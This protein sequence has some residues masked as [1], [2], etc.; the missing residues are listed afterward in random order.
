MSG[1]LYAESKNVNRANLKFYRA[2]E[3]LDYQL[4][5]SVWLREEYVKCVHPGAEMIIGYEAV[6]YSWKQIF[7]HTDHIRFS[8]RDIDVRVNGNLAWVTLTECVEAGFSEHERG[9]V[10]AA[11]NIF[12]KRDGQWFMIMH[13]SSPMLRRIGAE[14][15]PDVLPGII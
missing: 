11:S 1:G 12:E 15:P 4:M 10:V 7:E 13:H 5:T 14:L 2:F 3:S 6:M 9:T 8:V